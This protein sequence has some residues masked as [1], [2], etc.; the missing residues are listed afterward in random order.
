M[1]PRADCDRSA[2]RRA[3]SSATDVADLSSD[4]AGYA[5]AGSA[6]PRGVAA[7]AGGVAADR[8][9]QCM[10]VEVGDPPAPVLLDQIEVIASIIADSRGIRPLKL[11]S[12]AAAQ[13]GLQPGERD[14]PAPA[15]VW[16]AA[17]RPEAPTAASKSRA[18]TAAMRRRSASSGVSPPRLERTGGGDA[19]AIGVAHERPGAPVGQLAGGAAQACGRRAAPLPAPRDRP[20]PPST[21]ARSRPRCD[22]RAAPTRAAR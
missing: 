13:R 8:I 11:S 1:R 14:R 12:A 7:L 4:R 3:R 15:P 16:C 6:T 18:S 10:S 22:A 2:Q 9:L 19:P 5:R 17:A 21:G 20:G